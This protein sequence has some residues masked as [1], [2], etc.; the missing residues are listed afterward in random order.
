[1][2]AAVVLT[3]L[4]YVVGAVV[5]ATVVSALIVLRHRRPKSLEAG[6]EM[7][8]RE[9]QALAPD[10]RAQPQPEHSDGQGGEPSALRGSARSTTVRRKSSSLGKGRG[11]STSNEAGAASADS[12]AEPG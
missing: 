3:N 1:M 7:F 10:R 6:I 5:A 4:L 8:S 11:Y 9:L 2:T 12:E